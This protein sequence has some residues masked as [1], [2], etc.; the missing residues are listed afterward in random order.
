MQID[1]RDILFL[2]LGYPDDFKNKIKK[3]IDII[4]DDYVKIIVDPK[5]TSENAISLSRKL[6]KIDPLL[7]YKLLKRIHSP[8]RK[9]DF[10][11]DEL[12]MSLK[13]LELYKQAG[14]IHVISL[15]GVSLK[16]V[17]KFNVVQEVE[18]LILN[19]HKMGRAEIE[20]KLTEIIKDGYMNI[21]S[22]RQENQDAYYELATELI[23]MNWWFLKITN[24]IYLTSPKRKAEFESLIK[25][26]VKKL[27][28]SFQQDP[29]NAP[30]EKINKI[31]DLVYFI[32]KEDLKINLIQDLKKIFLDAGVDFSYES[33]MYSI[34]LFLKMK[35][36][37]QKIDE[38][39]EDL[40]TSP[41]LQTE[42]FIKQIEEVLKEG[43]PN[44]IYLAIKKMA[45]T[46]ALK[47]DNEEEIK[48]ILSLSQD[49]RELEENILIPY[50]INEKIQLLKNGEKRSI[51]F[52]EIIDLLKQIQ[53]PDESKKTVLATIINL[54]DICSR[55]E[56]RRLFKF[57]VDFNQVVKTLYQKV[58]KVLKLSED[59]ELS[60]LYRTLNEIYKFAKILTLSQGNG[61]MLLYC[62]ESKMFYKLCEDLIKRFP[63][64]NPNCF[65]KFHPQ[66]FRPYLIKKFISVENFEDAL[67]IIPPSLFKIAEGKKIED[68]HNSTVNRHPVN[69]LEFFIKEFMDFYIPVTSLNQISFKLALETVKKRAG[70]DF[71]DK[72]LLIIQKET[73]HEE[74][75]KLLSSLMEKSKDSQAL[76]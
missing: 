34:D 37:Q 20:K 50:Q 27:L 17:R 10:L 62:E 23:H 36:L 13:K 53:N 6:M 60:E 44:F 22:P 71:K 72:I 76:V 33:M 5:F 35:K 18:S 26:K 75:I 61:N 38:I 31:F 12:E 64:A 69:S 29:F 15:N 14:K 58:G 1:Q 52:K 45:T 39:T 59:A 28:N 49:C 51:H 67:C 24:L 4:H 16:P 30:K 54:F 40:N 66:I 8:E 57:K 25:L 47:K 41:P 46:A 32:S 73:R 3:N 68:L 21:D 2:L 7:L 19:L 11:L 43:T 48:T 55:S 65:G 70:G 9:K 63:D 74:T 56:L 42:H